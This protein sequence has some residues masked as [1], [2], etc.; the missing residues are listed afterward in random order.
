MQPEP[1]ESLDL[2]PTKEVDVAEGG[3]NIRVTAVV[4][5]VELALHTKGETVATVRVEGG[6]GY[7]GS[8]L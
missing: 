4:G 5:T 8:K 6:W 7:W 3:V 1:E 2:Q